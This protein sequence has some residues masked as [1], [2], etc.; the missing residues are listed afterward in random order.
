MSSTLDLWDPRLLHAIDCI[1]VDHATQPCIPEPTPAISQRTLILHFPRPGGADRVRTDDLRLARAALS[2][3]SYSPL[4]G[5]PL[6]RAPGDTSQQPSR[7]VGLG[8]F[9]LP[10]SRLSGVRS[11]QL[12]YRPRRGTTPIPWK[13]DRETEELSQRIDLVAACPFTRCIAA[14]ASRRPAPQKG[15]DP[16]TGSPTATLL[17]LHPNR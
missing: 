1:A 11:N 2:Q 16:A 9:E 12:S 7:V 15:G 14:W 4:S 6:T 8:R 5:G 10:T 3:L 17:R 13:L